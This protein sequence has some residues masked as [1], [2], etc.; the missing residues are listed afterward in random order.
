MSHEFRSES[1]YCAKG[2]IFGKHVRTMRSSRPESIQKAESAQGQ[3]E[4]LAHCASVLSGN[5]A[6]VYV[7]GIP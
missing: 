7:A 4:S 6:R 1:K 2:L 5:S 3:G